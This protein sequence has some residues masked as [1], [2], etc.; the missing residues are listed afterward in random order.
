MCS[1]A[2]L[3]K[4]VIELWPRFNNKPALM[5]AYKAAD[6][7][8]TGFVSK[9]EFMVRTPFITAKYKN[10]DAYGGFTPVIRIQET[11]QLGG[12]GENRYK[13]TFYV[14]ESDIEAQK[15]TNR[16]PLRPVG[17]QEPLDLIL[18]C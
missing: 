17:A 9:K 2:E 13:G 16:S 6:K 1:L 8:G 14:P 4:M 3:D 15:L 5:R 12:P 10:T 7:N 11:H 18:L